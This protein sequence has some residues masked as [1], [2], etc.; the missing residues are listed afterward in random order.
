M[1]VRPKRMPS[2]KVPCR[3]RPRRP[4]H[5]FAVD[6]RRCRRPLVFRRHLA[7]GRLTRRSGFRLP[8][9][10]HLLRHELLQL[11]SKAARWVRSII[12]GAKLLAAA[13]G[14]WSSAATPGLDASSIPARPSAVEHC[15]RSI[16]QLRPHLGQQAV[17]LHDALV[18]VILGAASVG[19][20]SVGGIGLWRISIRSASTSAVT[21][22]QRRG[23]GPA[24]AA[25]SMGERLRGTFAG[26]LNVW[27]RRAGGLGIR[28]RNS[29]Q[30]PR[31]LAEVR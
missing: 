19:S 4:R 12:R 6:V 15:A 16:Q 21:A 31:P 2:C 3:C 24:G 11:W 17:E 27:A 10:D 29:G 8:F 9:W 30:V 23:H 5:G 22:S 26:A 1:T 14:R 28:V 25:W 18:G 7:L 20:A 13:P